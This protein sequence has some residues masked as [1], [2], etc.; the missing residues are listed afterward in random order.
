LEGDEIKMRYFKAIIIAACFIIINLFISSCHTTEPENKFAISAEDCSSTEVWIRVQGS[1]G[2]QIILKRDDKEVKR[3]SI[4]DNEAVIVDDSLLPNKSYTYQ[5]IKNNEVSNAISITT[6]DT[7]SHNFTWQT[8]TFGSHS[9]YL[10]DV[11]I[12]SENDIW[13]VGRIDVADTSI[14]GYTTYNAV[15][16]DGEKWELRK[17]RYYGEC[18]LVE[19]PEFRA[20]WAFSKNNIVFTNG[21]SVGW[22]NGSEITLDCNVNPLLTGAINKIW[23]TNTNDLYLVGNNGSIT[24]HQNNQWSKVE[25]GTDLP[26]QDIW[27]DKGEVLAI[28]SDEFG[29]GGQ[30]L[31]SLSGNTAKHV[32]TDITISNSF[33]SIWFVSNRK[34][35]LAGDGLFTSYNISEQNWKLDNSISTYFYCIRGSSINNIAIVGENSYLAHFNGLNWKVY[36]ELENY[37]DRLTSVAVTDNMIVAVGYKYIDGF[38]RYG[39]VYIGRR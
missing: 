10:S 36:N 37:P 29:Y 7:T 20:N 33:S 35:F 25:S 13:A 18:S 34:Y 5:A 16:W 3:F 11:A 26:F 17:I 15:H 32:T 6:L 12:I 39:L 27:G 8:Y 2:S 1:S 22:Y 14:N 28:A 38:I 31:V 30:Y 19:Y 4:T 23:A 21:G 24:Y 9:S